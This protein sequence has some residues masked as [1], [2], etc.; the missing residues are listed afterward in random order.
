MYSTIPDFDLMDARQ[1]PSI[2]HFYTLR[3]LL[4]IVGFQTPQ[5][6]AINMRL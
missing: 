2:F 5:L 1:G 3:T 4:I 6:L